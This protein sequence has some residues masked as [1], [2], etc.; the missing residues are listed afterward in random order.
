M[1]EICKPI[2]EQGIKDLTTHKTRTTVRGVIIK[3]DQVLMVYSPQFNDYTFPGGG[4][5]SDE[6]LEDALLRELKEELGAD[7][8]YDIK[9]LGY[10]TEYRYGL[11]NNQQVYKQ[12]S[13]FFT[14][15]V[16]SLGRQDLVERELL[17]GVIPKWININK[18]IKHNN[19]IINDENHSKEGMQTV[20]QREN[21]V[22]EKILK[23]FTRYFA[24]VN[25]FNNKAI[26]LPVRATNYSA[27]YDFESA[28]DLIIKK[29]QIVLVPTGVKAHMLK[30]E[31]LMIHPRSSLAIKN[32]LMMPN[33][34]GV[35][36]ADYFNNPK[37][38]GHIMI[39]LYHLKDEDVHIK[40]GEKIAQG[41]FQKYLTIVD[42]STNNN[43]D[44][45]F[46]STDNK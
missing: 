10:L 29:N 38:E 28:E 36:D 27:G 34:V 25:S 20:I 32:G 33:S 42:D 17:H 7:Y 2:I 37:N 46:G 24:V 8:V 4:K 12:E 43:R 19:S 1:K 41:I 21:V 13:Y 26:N 9:E 18:A 30:D 14:C 5:K 15:Q 11:N 6:S 44:G 35:I 16:G 40:K 22:L 31:V 45:G 39:P 23:E 3:N